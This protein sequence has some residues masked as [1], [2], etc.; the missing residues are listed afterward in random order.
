MSW[1]ALTRWLRRRSDDDFA[2]EVESHLEMEVDRLV[3][4][5]MSERDAR[6]AA[7]RAFGNP[8]AARE[9]FHD[10]RP[11]AALESVV[12][13]AR[14][15]FRGMRRNPAFT[16]IAVASLAIGI[17]ANST[18][19]GIVDTLFLRSPAKVRDAERID[20]VY[21]QLPKGQAGA[22][23]LGSSFGYGVYTALRDRVRGFETV[24]A[25]W[26][27]QVSSGRGA[28]ARAIDAMAVTPSFFR[29]LGVQPALGRLL[30]PNEERDD[31]DHV[32]VL[33]YDAWHS[34]YA[35][36]SA[37]LGR[38][39]DVDGLP[40]T[41][42]GVMPEGF[43]GINLDRVDLW[44]PLGLAT[45]EFPG[46]DALDPNSHSY[47]LEIIAKRRVAASDAEIAREATQAFHDVFRD[48]PRYDETIGKSRAVLGPL[49]AAR[50]PARGASARVAVWL[51]VVSLVVLLIACANVAT[52]MLLRG[53]TR[54]RETALRVS[55]GAARS[56]LVRQGLVVGTLLAA[57]GAVAALFVA[58]ATGS[59]VRTYLLPNAATAPASDVRLTTYTVALAIVAGLLASIVPAVIAARRDL[60]PLVNA[61]RSSAS[62]ERLQ[63]QRILI[64]GQVAL[65]MLLLVGAGLF[66]ASL[67]NVRAID[68]G[69]D[70][71]H[72]LCVQAQPEP[73]AKTDDKGSRAAATATY[74]AMLA[75]VRQ[76]PGV[77][78]ATLTAGAPFAS[79]WG[80]SIRRRGAPE[81]APGTPMPFGR[82]VGADYFQTMGTRL[83]RGRYFTAADHSP[84]S[85]VAIVD[86]TTA[87]E[88]W[89]HEDPLDPCVYVG[90]DDYCTQIVGVV[91][92]TALW[93][94]TGDRGKI[95][96]FPL[97]GVVDQVPV[98]MME[99]RTHGDPAPL[100][101]A[102]RQAVTSV[103]PNLPWVNIFPLSRPYDDQLRP[104]RLGASMFSAFGALALL[105][106]AVG[107]YGLLSY[108]VTQRTH[109]IGVRK[110]LGAGNGRLIRMVLGDA[111]STTIAGVAVGLLLA[112]GAVR[113][114]AHL[115]YGISPDN[116]AVL[117][118]GAAVLLFA[119]V[120]ACLAPA[121]RAAR[122]DPLVAL[123]SE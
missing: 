82:G 20:R 21:L 59:I 83:L 95:V 6:F 77:V 92:N 100:I 85:H 24:G 90:T 71:D 69:F 14:Y 57:A 58:R 96:Y 54:A 15:A 35:G 112:L 80:V 74:R 29:V 121:R 79:G 34:W 25:F 89:P 17:G 37:V 73:G 109:E 42:V 120:V 16:M 44:V 43:T 78:S 12:Q 11:G 93:Q 10:A 48:E 18:I 13:D 61:A 36:D 26:Q 115:L 3:A 52:L 110:A 4:T 60:G 103:S 113:L 45:R 122:V 99:V 55:L 117:A 53:I 27:L 67:R 91:A 105:L 86:E 87:R 9:R 101:P 84:A 28:G 19:F 107:L 38:H 46:R 64:S 8:T 94:V 123:R 106:A 51:A 47:W 76:V 75:R 72:I 65:A 5:G 70:I 39:I 116:P 81:P 88:Y 40:Y 97:E 31:G 118:L 62:R 108:A 33:G 2:A 30:S 104:W 32:A 22:A 7:R 114:I 63:L 102:V 98:S 41:I 56:R 23:Q 1:R 68:M 111:M 66:V 49:A 119:A 50:G